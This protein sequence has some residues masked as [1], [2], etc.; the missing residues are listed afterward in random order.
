MDKENK[1]KKTE[2][3]TLKPSESMISC[4]NKSV[5]SLATQLNICADV[6]R[7]C[8]MKPAGR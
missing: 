5:Y 7:Q 8:S 4:F 1:V 2:N 3:E 6:L